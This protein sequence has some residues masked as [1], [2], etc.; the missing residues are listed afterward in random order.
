M[1]MLTTDIQGTHYEE[2]RYKV[3]TNCKREFDML[4]Y[5]YPGNI[6][7]TVCYECEPPRYAMST[8]RKSI[9]WDELDAL[10][11]RCLAD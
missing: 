5:G 9:T 10:E 7:R 6:F 4:R 11:D 3:C 1:E 2:P 8:R